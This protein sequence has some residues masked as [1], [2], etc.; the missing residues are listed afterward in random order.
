MYWYV[1]RQL[2]IVPYDR[3]K[4][5]QYAREWAFKRNPRYYNFDKLGGDCTNFAS[6]VIYAGSGVMNYDKLNG[7]YYINLNNRSPS[8]TAVVYLY[9]FLTQNR[10][11]GPFASEVDA[12]DVLPGDIV[13]LSFHDGDDIFDHSPVIVSTGAVPSPE[14][15]LIAAHTYDRLDY[16]VSNYNYRRIR[17]LHIE[18]VR[19]WQ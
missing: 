2:K 3:A 7:W 10:G 13:Q 5:V 19:K 15:I 14:N 16:P 9:K 18:G 1:V 12:K 6:Q 11:V 4:A 8:W 17:Y